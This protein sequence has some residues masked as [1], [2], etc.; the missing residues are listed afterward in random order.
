MAWIRETATSGGYWI[1]SATDVIVADSL[2][3]TGSIGVASIRPDFSE[4]LKKVG[5]DVDTLLSHYKLNNNN[6]L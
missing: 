6:W 3:T 5:I 2:S 1:A 4:F